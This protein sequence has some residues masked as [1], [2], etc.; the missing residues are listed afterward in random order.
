MGVEATVA[1]HDV[2]FN[3]FEERLSKM[4]TGENIQGDGER[5]H[6]EEGR[7]WILKS[8]DPDRGFHRVSLSL[9]GWIGTEKSKP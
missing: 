9:D 3:F 5:Q 7:Q 4:E 1:K 2:K 8:Q 6:Q